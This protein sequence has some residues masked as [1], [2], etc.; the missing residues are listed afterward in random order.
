MS[1]DA[2]APQDGAVPESDDNERQ[3][4][5]AEYV[6]KLRAESAKHRTEAK[7]NAE[8]ARRLAELE[9]AQKTEQQKLAERA[10]AAASRTAELE[11]QNLHLRTALEKGLPL[12]LVDRL[13]GDTPE[14]VAADADTLLALVTPADREPNSPGFDGGARQ[15][16]PLNGDPLLRSVKTKLGIR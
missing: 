9:E 4:F 11:R 15:A 13:R 6:K 14:E 3:T 2:A 5:D 12:E 10:E 16:T 7:A 1:D 8:A